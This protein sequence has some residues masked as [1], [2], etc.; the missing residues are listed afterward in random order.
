LLSRDPTQI[1]VAWGHNLLLLFG[2][3]FVYGLASVVFAFVVAAFAPHEFGPYSAGAIPWA[4]VAFKTTLEA[5]SIL[6]SVVTGCV[7]SLYLRF[8]KAAWALLGLGAVCALGKYRSHYWY[9]VPELWEQAL[10]LLAAVFVAILMPAA[11][12]LCQRLRTRNSP[13]VARCYESAPG[14]RESPGCAPS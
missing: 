10:V 3:S 14:P 11:F 12:L 2:L 13:V 1:A 8:R 7:A 9:Q 5:A 4:M 6:A